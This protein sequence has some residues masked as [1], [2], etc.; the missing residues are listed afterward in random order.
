MGRAGGVISCSS[1]RP[2]QANR[3]GVVGDLVGAMLLDDAKLHP[4]VPL[5][6]GLIF[7]DN[8]GDHLAHAA[9]GEPNRVQRKRR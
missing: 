7:A 3:G 9:V 4:S 2:G 8:Q 5:E 1:P 6:R